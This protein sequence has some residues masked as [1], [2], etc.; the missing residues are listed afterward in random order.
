MQD[1]A[2]LEAAAVL[3]TS[4]PVALRK[5]AVC[6]RDA[7]ICRALYPGEVSCKE[8]AEWNE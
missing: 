4:V 6:G 1:G 7:G 2:L 8:G 3:R 5:V